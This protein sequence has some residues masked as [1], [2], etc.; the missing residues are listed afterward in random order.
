MTYN[1]APP[2]SWSGHAKRAAVGTT[3]SPGKTWMD[4][5]FSAQYEQVRASM[6]SP[7]RA[8]HFG[9]T[10]GR[11]GRGLISISLPRMKAAS[12]AALD[13]DHHASRAMKALWTT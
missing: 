13:D 8:S 4:S 9:S 7:M 2:G 1:H 12:S 11:A 5:A 10:G 3:A 6:A